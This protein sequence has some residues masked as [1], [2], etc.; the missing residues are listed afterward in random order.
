MVEG[1]ADK[2]SVAFVFAVFAFVGSSVVTGSLNI[3]HLHH[4]VYRTHQLNTVAALLSFLLTVVAAIGKNTHPSLLSYC[5]GGTTLLSS[6]ISLKSQQTIVLHVIFYLLGHAIA[7]VYKLLVL[8]YKAYKYRQLT[9]VG[10]NKCTGKPKRILI[11][12]ASVGSGHKRAA[13]AIEQAI[14]ARVVEEGGEVVSDNVKGD[15]QGD[16]QDKVVV[17]VLD[18]IDTQEWFLRTVYKKGFMTLVGKD[19]GQAFIGLMFDKSNQQ[20]P[21]LEA[22]QHGFFQTVLE[23]AFS[24]SFVEYLFNFKPDI[25]VNTHFLGLKIVSHLRQKLPAFNVPQVTAVTDFD[26]HAY[27][28]CQPCEQFFVARDECRHALQEMGVSNDL[29]QITGMPI[30]EAFANVRPKKACLSDLGLTGKLPIILLMV[31]GE[32]IFETYDALLQMQTSVEIAL[33]CGRHEDLRG[34]LSAV[35]VPKR[36]RVVIEGFTRVMHEY[37]ACA[38]LIITKPGGLTTAESLAMGTAIVVYHSLPGQ[39][40]RNADMIL[41][42]GAGIKV[43][44]SRMLGYKI[45]KLLKDKKRLRRMQKNA[46]RIGSTGSADKIASYIFNGDYYDTYMSPNGSKQ[47]KL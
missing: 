15:A 24:L 18:I 21:G 42:E 1:T 33:V 28:A 7:V 47:K 14:R 5:G 43:N 8:S 44:D 10:L 30:V 22:G 11:I 16:R 26:V 46:L 35:S 32:D 31:G 17:K 40:L 29:I 9:K 41:E 36:H 39:E 13:Q 38:D 19:W 2:I 4:H 3:F 23:E 6:R 20:A 34:R 25:I 27:W 45:E 37:L 12:H